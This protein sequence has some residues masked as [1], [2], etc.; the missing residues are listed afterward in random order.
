MQK[1]EG[2]C[3]DYMGHGSPENFIFIFLPLK[4][5]GQ[6]ELYLLKGIPIKCKTTVYHLADYSKYSPTC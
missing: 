2:W 6:Q 4:Q 5:L 3:L 1:S